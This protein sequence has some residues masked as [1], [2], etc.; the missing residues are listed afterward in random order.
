VP[1]PPPPQP[2]P[3][4]LTQAAIGAAALAGLTLGSGFIACKAFEE[5]LRID[6]DFAAGPRE[7]LAVGSRAIL[8]FLL[9]WA[10]ATAVVAALGALWLLARERL[11]GSVAGRWMRRWETSDPVALGTVVCLA[12][13]VGCFAITAWFYPIFTALEAVRTATQLPTD[14]P[15]LQARGANTSYGELSA[16]LSF[17]LG[18]AA[19]K[20]FP[21]LED[22]S[23]DKTTVRALRW[24]T[25]TVAA[26]TIALSVIPRRV[27]WDN[28]EVVL[29]EKQRAF[30]IGDNGEQLLLY[31]PDSR[32]RLWQRVPSTGGDLERTGARQRLFT[33]EQ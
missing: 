25:V 10:T 6:P 14:V 8:P 31:R 22:R 28:F 30:V 7:V 3:P 23:A 26:V 5:I 13:V 32:G 18:W 27:V 1:P 4:W 29:Y 33:R 2:W 12:G 21:G 20:W 16:F 11:G 17:A 9:V 24:A 19:W 15:V